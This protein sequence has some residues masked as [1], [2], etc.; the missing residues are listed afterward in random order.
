MNTRLWLKKRKPYWDRLEEILRRSGS[1]GLNA[2]TARVLRETGLLYRQVAADL[3]TVREDPR[4]QRMAA[5]LNRLLGGAHNLIYLGRRSRKS[6]IWEFYRAD[7]PRIFR[8]TLLYTL[9]AF[10]LFL[11]GALI[12]LLAAIADPTFARSFLGPQMADTIARRQMWTH[13]IVGMQP[14]A[15][16]AIMTNNLTVSFSAFATG[17]TVVGTIYMMVFN[18][19]LIGVIGAACHQ[20]GMSLQ[21]WSFVAP[22]G[23]LELPAIFLAGGGGLLI[24]RGLIFP[25]LLGRRDALQLYGGQGVRL[26]LGVIPLLVIAGLVEGFL[27]PSEL[28]DTMKF[29]LAGIN[30]LLLIWYLWKAGAGETTTDPAL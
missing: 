18:G 12:G 1:A 30:A 22:H 2:L 6:A 4:N 5:Y 20:A 17:F 13:S 29:G 27:S 10:T 26:A 24:A 7:F 19:L 23:T 3:A 21:L 15:S 28:P 16:S 11:L 25:G 8:A 9:A 14:V